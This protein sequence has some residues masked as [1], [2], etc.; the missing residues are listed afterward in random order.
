M[1][2]DAIVL[3]PHHRRAAKAIAPII[4]KRIEGADGRL[5]VA[6]AGESGSGKSET[7]MAIKEALATAGIETVVLQQD[8]YYVHPP[9]TNDRA[10]REDIAWVGPKEVRLPLLDKHLEQFKA[11]AQSL[12]KPLVLYAEDTISEETADL[13]GAS[14]VIAEG[15]YT[16]LLENADVRIFIARDMEQTRAHREKRKRDAA[17]L[18]VFTEQVLR[19]EHDIIS[20]HR[21]LA[22]IV[23]EPDYTITVVG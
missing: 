21:K 16:S 4:M 8:D 19:I 12:A 5:T 15:T 9:K 2:G 23:I 7:A 13:G 3:E 14:V 10:R 22:D 17:E 20:R 11:G 1:R 18:D 6:V